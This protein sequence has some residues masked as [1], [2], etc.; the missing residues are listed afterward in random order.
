MEE[1]KVEVKA[2]TLPKKKVKV[3]LVNRARG[4]VK[5]PDHVM[6]NLAPGATIDICPRNLPGTSTIDCPLTEAE[7]V[8]FENKQLSGMAFNPGD[9]SPYNAKA[10]N[11]WRSKRANVRLDNKELELNLGNPG[12]YLKYK[13]LISNTD[14]IAVGLDNEFM[15]KSYIYV[16]TDQEDERKKAGKKGDKQKRAWKIAGKIEDSRETMINYLEIVGKRPST[17]SPLEFLQAEIVKEIENNIDLFLEVLEDEQFDTRVLITKSLQ[18]GTVLRNGHKYT[19]ANEEPL[20]SA[21]DIN[22]LKGAMDFLEAKEN[23]DIRL[24]LEARLNKDDE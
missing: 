16:I 13:I 4:P 14:L 23:Q 21:G 1:E 2:F 8:F 19:L 20:C 12:D 22:N 10:D 18:I 9:L 6:Y 3:R 7:K 11:F 24:A 5:D 17:D 15:K